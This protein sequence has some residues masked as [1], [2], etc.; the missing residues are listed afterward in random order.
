MI[1][2]WAAY[3][4]VVGQISSHTMRKTWYRAMIDGYHEPLYKMMWALEHSSKRQTVQYIGL[5]T[6][7][8]SG[9]YEHVL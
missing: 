8:V 1:K 4:G 5:L 3:A 2:Q 7:E 6:D 9:L